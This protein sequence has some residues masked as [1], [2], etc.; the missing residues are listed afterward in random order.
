MALDPRQMVERRPLNQRVDMEIYHRQQEEFLAD[1]SITI[2]N[3]PIDVA[4]RMIPSMVGDLVPYSCPL[5]YVAA[6]AGWKVWED[7][8]SVDGFCGGQD[9]LS[10][11]ETGAMQLS[12]VGSRMG[13]VIKGG[14]VPADQIF[15]PPGESRDNLNDA[16]RVGMR[17]KN[18]YIT[19]LPGVA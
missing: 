16:L 12:K 8:E 7:G 10:T 13:L 1:P 4:A 2:D 15:L 9:G 3:T 18:F 14:K 5:H 17:A 11:V 19:N 6:S